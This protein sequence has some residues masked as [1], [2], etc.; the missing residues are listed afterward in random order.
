MSCFSDLVVATLN[1]MC[2]MLLIRETLAT[3][4]PPSADLVDCRQGQFVNFL[5]LTGPLWWPHDVL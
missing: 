2:I 4:R 5:I 1:P 3:N